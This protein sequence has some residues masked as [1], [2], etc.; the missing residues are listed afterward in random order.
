MILLPIV[1][2]IESKVLSRAAAPISVTVL[3]SP[4]VVFR[5]SAVEHPSVIGYDEQVIL[6]HLFARK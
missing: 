4:P 3:F 2:W 6:E 1:K 5:R